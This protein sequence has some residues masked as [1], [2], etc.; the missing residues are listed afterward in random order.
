[1]DPGRRIP[2]QELTRRELLRSGAAGAAAAAL[3]GL[4]GLACGG[5][6][7][8][9]PAAGP[10]P[11]I[12]L[13][14]S[15]SHRACSMGCYG[16]PDVRTPAFDAFAGQGLRLAT[17]VSNTPLCRP[18]RAS[19]MAGRFSHHTGLLT[20]NRYEGN[21]GVGQGG[22]WE[23]ARLGIKTLGES[24]RAAGYRCSYLGKWHL[25]EVDLDPGP[26]RFGFDDDWTAAARNATGD[27]EEGA[28]DYWSWTYFTG[29]DRSFSG[30][31]SFRTTMETD[32]LLEYLR[33]R[34]E[35]RRSGA[36]DRPWLMVASWG[37]P[38][39]PFTPPEEYRRYA[40]IPLP[41]NIRDEGLRSYAREN[42]PLYYALIEAI[43]HE[44]GRL[45]A[46]LDALG[47]G[48]DTLVIYT[49]DHGNMHGSQ[50]ALGKELPFDEAT[51]VPFL[52]RWPG[53]IAAGSVLELPF[54]TPDV[55]PTLAGLAGVEAPAGLDGRDLSSALLGRPGAARQ[56]AVLLQDCHSRIFPR[57]G[58][59]G[60]RTP[61][62]LFARTSSQNWILFD[63]AADPLCLD[64]LIGRKLPSQKEL[65]ALLVELMAAVGDSWA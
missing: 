65:Q 25:G 23:P 17:A 53:R 39:E 6:A 44:F 8:S 43:D 34:A 28:H 35:D 51:R 24:F 16:N 45:V 3:A 15:D 57:P 18:Y 42:L 31:G 38:H 5:Q 48:D 58:W 47:L 36:D 11:N 26:L 59:R 33:A 14:F 9:A 1:M 10:R 22:Q 50:D 40:E 52:L 12:L 13:V 46:G 2:A 21:F 56:E 55:L 29:K 27:E 19:V 20:N 61:Q 63:V 37:P 49:S 4:P 7:G 41:A 60:V 30:G 54:G 62:W 32:R 64:N